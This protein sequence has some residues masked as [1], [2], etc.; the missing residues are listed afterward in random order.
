MISQVLWQF[1]L[2]GH[3]ANSGARIAF[4]RSHP[5]YLPSTV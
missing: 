5:R 2:Q 1:R 3:D 4:R